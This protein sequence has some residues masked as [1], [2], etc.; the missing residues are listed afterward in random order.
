MPPFDAIND[1][2]VLTRAALTTLGGFAGFMDALGGDGRGP[3]ATPTLLASQTL[4]PRK[5]VG[6][7]DTA[8]MVVAIAA[9]AEF[10]ADIGLAQ[11]Y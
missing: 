3:I 9:S 6:S 5:V 11:I 4:E 7:V 1:P 10:V 8:E 2:W